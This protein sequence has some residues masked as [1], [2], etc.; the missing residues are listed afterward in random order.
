MREAV[1]G[2]VGDRVEGCRVLDLFA[3]VGAFGLEAVSRGARH[4]VFVETA[5]KNIETLQKNIA[6]LGFGMQADV[7]C[8]DAFRTPDLDSTQKPFGL[9]FIDPPFPL[10]REVE[11]AEQIFGRVSDLLRSNATTAKSLIVLRAPTG[12][13][14]APPFPQYEER[15]YGQSRVFFFDQSSLTVDL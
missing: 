5:L 11:G 10:Y 3:G 6:T 4:A 14:D 9:V 7:L 1:F 2:I 15:I 13:R 12:Y 8:D